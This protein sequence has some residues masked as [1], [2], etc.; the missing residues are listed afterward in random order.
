MRR[1]KFRQYVSR[2]VFA[3][4]RWPHNCLFKLTDG[5]VKQPRTLAQSRPQGFFARL[6]SPR[7]PS[8]AFAHLFSSHYLD[9][10]PVPAIGILLASCAEE[11]FWSPGHDG[12]ESVQSLW[13]QPPL[14]VKRL[15]QCHRSLVSVEAALDREEISFAFFSNSLIADE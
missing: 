7:A 10:R 12:I 2:F 6:S 15:R 14:T 1:C 13:Q 11:L 5:I 8:R 3:L 4:L 9:Y